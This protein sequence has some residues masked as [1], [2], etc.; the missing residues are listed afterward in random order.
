MTRE[1]RSEANE[2]AIDD[3]RENQS[4]ITRR[5]HDPMIACLKRFVLARI[6]S[7]VMTSVTVVTDGDVYH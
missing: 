5:Q 4:Q 7:Q 1:T 6:A 3:E 2:L